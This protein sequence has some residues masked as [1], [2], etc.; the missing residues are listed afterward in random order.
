MKKNFLIKGMAALA[1]LALA[2][3]SH[4]EGMS[5]E[6]FKTAQYNAE[7]VK[8]FGTIDPNQDWG[9]GGGTRAVATRALFNETWVDNHSCDWKDKLEFSLPN[10]YT[11]VTTN[12]QIKSGNAYYV[13]EN[14]NG[15][16]NFD[17]FNGDLYVAGKVTNFNGNPGTLNLYILEK[18]TWSKGFTTGTI[19]I[20]NNGYLILG[21]YDLQNS[22]VQAIYN[23]GNFYLGTEGNGVNTSNS[24]K[25]YSTGLVEVTGSGT[26]DFKF[27]SDI[28]GK[29]KVNGNIKIQNGTPKYICGIEA[30]GKVENVDGALITSYIKASDLS[31]DGNPL[32][33]TKGG[34]VD[35][36]K[37]ISITNSNCHVYAD[38][39]GKALIEATNFE[40]G[41]KN[42]FTHTFTQNIYFKV[43]G[44]YVECNN[45]YAMGSSHHFN[46]VDEYLAYT[47][48]NANQS[49]EYGLAKDRINAGSASGSPECGDAWTVGTDEIKEKGR[50]F[51]EDLGAIGDF[52]FNDVVFDA[53]IYESGKVEIEV[54]AAGGTLPLSVAGVDVHTL[55]GKGIVNTGVNAGIAKS[56]MISLT[57]SEAQ[58]LNISYINDIPVVVS[59]SVGAGY[60]EVLL[61]SK[62]GEAPQK[63]CVPL[64]T[65]WMMEYESIETGYPLFNEYVGN[66]SIGEEAFKKENRGTNLYSVDE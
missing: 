28:H 54:W 35:V 16:I 17:N 59:Q 63:I 48:H 51:C 23:G 43:N 20:Y 3:C 34:H 19:N 53:Y 9:F 4:E 37:T 44:G 5:L 2:S 45:C 46:T 58:A 18:G 8:K 13:P 11:T 65:P 62:V 40:F 32:Y 50:V 33:L 64:G 24:V 30:T 41:N 57:A 36:A 14:F 21:G 42:D 31:F 55:L 7:F 38:S 6:E 29:L 61:K 25:L 26:I 39:N 47:G 52:D 66:A 22:N 27:V 1:V 15:T 49:D 10:D 56:A 60:S 12:T